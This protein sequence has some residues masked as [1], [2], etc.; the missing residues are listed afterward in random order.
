M[1]REDL[2]RGHVYEA[3]R[4]RRTGFNFC[5]DRMLIYMGTYQVQ[6]DSP[7]LQFGSK[8]PRVTIEKFLAWAGRDVT[9]E[10]PPKSWRDWNARKKTPRKKKSS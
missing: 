5:N 3:K 7:V 2:I 1:I 4:P 10:T 8:Y 9:E 6:Y